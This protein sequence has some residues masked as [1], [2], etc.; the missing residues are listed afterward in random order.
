MWGL[1]KREELG[2]TPRVLMSSTGGT[3]LPLTEMER[4]LG[5]DGNSGMTG[6]GSQVLSLGRG[7]FEMSTSTQVE[8]SGR[9]LHLAV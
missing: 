7:E 6:L 2:M 9:Q 8:V 5:E 3:E 1:K 4:A